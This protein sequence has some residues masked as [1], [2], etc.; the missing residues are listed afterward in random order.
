MVR[1]I[2]QYKSI[3]RSIRKAVISFQILLLLKIVYSFP[4]LP[5]IPRTRPHPLNIDP[6]LDVTVQHHADESDASLGHD[7]RDA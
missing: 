7:P 6:A 5:N 3:N 4:I 2:G 1:I